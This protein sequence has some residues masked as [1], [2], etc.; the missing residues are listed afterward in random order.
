MNTIKA[1]QK[2]HSVRHFLEKE[3]S[4]QDLMTLLEAARHSPSGSKTQ[5]WQLAAVRGKAKQ[6]LA[7]VMVSAFEQGKTTDPAYQYSPYPMPSPYN[8]RREGC[9]LKLYQTLNIARN[10]K[11]GQ[12]AEWAANYRSFDT[13][14][15]LL[16]GWKASCKPVH[17]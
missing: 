9:G 3:V 6:C 13:P 1:M 2:C 14:V 11:T 7:D 5:P 17:I 8:D 4:Q 10:D 12:R 16:S 15:T